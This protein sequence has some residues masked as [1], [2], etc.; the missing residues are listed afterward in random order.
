ME[1]LQ[2]LG[3]TAEAEEILALMG[4]YIV[5]LAASKQR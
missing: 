4:D 2:Y 1:K 5:K 3:N